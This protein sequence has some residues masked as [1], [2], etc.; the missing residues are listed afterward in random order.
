[1]IS[2]IAETDT[3]NTISSAT[4]TIVTAV[5]VFHFRNQVVVLVVRRALRV[6]PM[7]LLRVIV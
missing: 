5:E 4:T 2:Q 1:M 6:E 7:T 3:V